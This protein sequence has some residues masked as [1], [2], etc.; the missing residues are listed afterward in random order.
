MP[1]IF[2]NPGRFFE[3]RA[4]I[5]RTRTEDLVDPSLFHHRIGSPANAGIGEKRL[6]ILQ[7][8]DGLV[9]QIFRDAVAINA[10]GY[11]YLVPVDAEFRRTIGEGEGDLRVTDRLAVVGAIENDVGHFAA[12]QGL[13]RLLAEDPAH[14]VEHVGFSTAV[15]PD[16]SGDALVEIKDRLVG[17]GF[18][19]EELE[20]LKM[21]A[22]GS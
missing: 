5:F 4:P 14:G 2:G 21:H 13:G 1:F 19:P 10:A 18:K 17:E 9:K 11:A 12:A 6:D 15:R 7:P 3:N 16:D 8:A 20:G 22:V